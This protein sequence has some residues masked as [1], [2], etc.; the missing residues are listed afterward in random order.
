LI[1]G[2]LFLASWLIMTLA[3]CG[4]HPTPGPIGREKMCSFP[5]FSPCD[6]IENPNSTKGIITVSTTDDVTGEIIV[7]H[8]GAVQKIMPT[9]LKTTTG[10]QK[11]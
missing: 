10:I 11:K 1:L 5:R 8:D 3:Y 6:I 9:K 2:E 7:P 4:N